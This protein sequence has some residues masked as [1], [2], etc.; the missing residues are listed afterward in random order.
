[1]RHKTLSQNGRLIN[2]VEDCRLL[3]SERWRITF[4]L[5]R[6]KIYNRHS[7]VSLLCTDKHGHPFSL[8]YAMPFPPFR[9]FSN[10]AAG[11]RE[12][13]ARLEVDGARNYSALFRPGPLAVQPDLDKA[14]TDRGASSVNERPVTR[15]PSSERQQGKN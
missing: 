14:E 11:F 6:G 8:L 4:P 2:E 1:M 7:N 9:I 5:Y 3:F 10:A 15:S 13:L 12:L